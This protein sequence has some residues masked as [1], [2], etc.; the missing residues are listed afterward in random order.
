VSRQIT[1]TFDA[2]NPTLLA[3][4]W[5]IAREYE[6]AGPPPG[7]ASWDDFADANAIPQE[8]RRRDRFGC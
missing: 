7:F 3:N 1:I 2:H 5:A 6:L 8:N 4:F